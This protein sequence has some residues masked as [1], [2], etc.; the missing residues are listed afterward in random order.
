MCFKMN[1]ENVFC[2]NNFESKYLVTFEP[3]KIFEMKFH[4]C[5]T[6]FTC[7]TVDAPIFMLCTLAFDFNI[8]FRI[9]G[10]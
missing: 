2:S 6:H 10:T 8:Y 4:I 1:L 7:L 9:H 5:L 3:L